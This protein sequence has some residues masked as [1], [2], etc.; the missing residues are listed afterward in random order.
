EA[1]QS[2][3]GIPSILPPPALPLPA[4]EGHTAFDPTFC[5]ACLPRP[6][7]PYSMNNLQPPNLQCA[8][9]EN[10]ALSTIFH[11]TP[12]Y[13]SIIPSS[14]S[15]HCTCTLMPLQPTFS[16]A[17]SRSGLPIFGALFMDLL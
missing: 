17:C 1:S 5:N 12:A 7:T 3:Q 8:K 15:P 16:I 2:R 13:Y 14:T 6:P 4:L 11:A 9:F 10:R